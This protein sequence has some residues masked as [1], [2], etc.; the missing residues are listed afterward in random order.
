MICAKWPQQAMALAGIAAHR[1]L[2][3]VNALARLAGLGMLSA[4]LG[5]AIAA[6]PGDDAVFAEPTSGKPVSRYAVELSINGEQQRRRFEIPDECT[7]VKRLF[8]QRRADT[9]R[10]V[11]RRLW[12]KVS[13][14]CWF[15]AFLNRHPFRGITDYVTDYDFKNAN[16]ADL[17]IDSDCASDSPDDAL[18]GCNPAAADRHGLLRHFPLSVLE[19]LGHDHPAAVDCLLRDGVFFGRLYVG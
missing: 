5:S 17:P 4:L 13:E 6:Y 18:I 1:T 15:H 2:A 19:G 14:D 11:D 16:L 8:E 12:G 7:E 9:T 3:T 10:I